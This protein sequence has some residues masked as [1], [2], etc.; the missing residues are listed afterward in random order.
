VND[1]LKRGNFKF[2]TEVEYFDYVMKKYFRKVP[3]V[4]TNIYLNS[5]QSRLLENRM[6]IASLCHF[7]S[8]LNILLRDPE[9]SVQS[10]ARNNDFWPLI[11]ELQDVL[12]FEK[13]E[14][15]EFARQEVF[16]IMLVLLLFEDD[17]D[18][19]REVLRNAS[20]STQMLNTY[21]QLLQ[22]RSR[23][24]KDQVILSESQ[25]ILAEKKQRIVK[26]ADIRK[27]A[28]NFDKPEAQRTLL[29]KLADEDKVIRKAVNNVLL[30]I[31][32]APL[33]QFMRLAVQ[34]QLPDSTLNHYIILTELLNLISR[35]DDLRQKPV[36]SLIAE[37]QLAELESV[38]GTDY[39]TRI[40][41]TR[42]LELLDGCQ[43]D[44]TNFQNVLLL[45]TCHG[46][47]NEK[48]RSVAAGILSLDDIFALV[49]D[50]STPQQHFKA[51]LDILSEHPDEDIRKRVTATYHN[52]SERLWNRLKE[53]EQS[54]NAYFDI[55]FQTLGFDQINEYN[56]SLKSIEESEKTINHLTP[57]LET[58][59]DKQLQTTL[60]TFSEIKKHIEL[61]IYHINSAISKDILEELYHIE[62]MIDQIFEL[63]N[64]GKEGLRPGGL[65]G[66]DPELLNRAHT[67][68][69]SAL[70]QYLGRIKHLNEMIK[71]KFS[72]LAK[73][74]EKHENLQNDFIEVV[75]SFEKMQK[76]TVNCQLKVACTRCVRRGCAAERF[77]I[78]TD[79]FI[80]ELL[81]NFVS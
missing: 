69:Q 58:E 68:W 35:R 29:L 21:I 34:D 65:S 38:S 61:Q 56:I 10:A 72:I 43:E 4:P 50:L 8:V 19:L 42:R 45:A 32:P 2:A 36:Q 64:F 17:I 24:K 5:P 7:P 18:V 1:L 27:A 70:G 15:K 44:L 78:E 23:G 40:L 3:P 57:Q 11:G 79:F 80:K 6:Q 26:A 73:E 66:I 49:N 60:F 54:I 30:D 76:E 52:E 22:S 20:L 63:K 37:D 28:K 25:K 59:L 67:I 48:I 31:K 33:L 74:F 41:N 9:Y 46:D 51:I 71:I 12:G 81:D 16:R 53:L 75:E 13:R 62:D 77:L 47:S 39:L 55:I 14:R